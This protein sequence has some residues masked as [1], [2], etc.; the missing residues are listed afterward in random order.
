MDQTE[1]EVELEGGKWLFT[2]KSK[3]VPAIG[4][5][6]LYSTPPP[7]RTE[8]YAKV[9]SV[10]WHINQYRNGLTKATLVVKMVKA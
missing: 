3:H 8:Q 1:I 7:A 9:M 10:I 4:D 2:Y 6:V 5:I